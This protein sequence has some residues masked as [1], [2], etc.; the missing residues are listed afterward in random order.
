MHVKN[1]GL[2]GVHLVIYHVSWADFRAWIDNYIDTL[3]YRMHNYLCP[4]FNAVFKSTIKF[5]LWTTNNYIQKLYVIHPS[6]IN[7]VSK[8]GYSWNEKCGANMLQQVTIW[9]LESELYHWII[10][11]KRSYKGPCTL[12][13]ASCHCEIEGFDVDL[14]YSK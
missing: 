14:P 9:R 11:S 2:P 5:M 8:E 4:G 13:N 10:P 7:Y 3:N 1:Y 12:C 6:Q